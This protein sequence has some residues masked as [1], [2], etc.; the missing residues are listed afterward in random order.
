MKVAATKRLKNLFSKFF[1]KNQSAKAA[2][3]RNR[4][5]KAAFKKNQNAIV[6][7]FT[8]CKIRE[9]RAKLAMGK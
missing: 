3:K 2:S 4:G 8:V 5:E 1:Q 7:A 6:A 9:K